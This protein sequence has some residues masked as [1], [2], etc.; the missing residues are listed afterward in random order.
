MKFFGW[1][2][3][4]GAR[5][6]IADGKCPAGHDPMSRD[7]S[8]RILADALS[9]GPCMNMDAG[10]CGD[11]ATGAGPAGRRCWDVARK[12]SKNR[13]RAYQGFRQYDP[14]KMCYPCAAAWH[15]EMAALYLEACHKADLIVRAVTGAVR[16]LNAAEGGVS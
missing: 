7:E 15:A 2:T 12:A 8:A 6:E 13:K 1:C 4:C 14:E 3:T 9:R 16:K 10:G 11:P 5:V